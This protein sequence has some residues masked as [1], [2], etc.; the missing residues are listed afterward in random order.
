M[1]IG[2]DNEQLKSSI[3]RILSGSAGNEEFLR[4]LE[5]AIT[6]SSV[7]DPRSEQ[8]LSLLMEDIEHHGRVND[9]LDAVSKDS[10]SP[11][12]VVNED[13]SLL[14]CNPA[15]LALAGTSAPKDL[16]SLGV[17]RSDFVKFRERLAKLGGTSLLKVSFSDQSESERSVVF[18]GQY[19]S[20]SRYYLLE[21]L[22]LKW[23]ESI[24]QALHELFGL[25]PAEREVLLCMARGMPVG[26]ISNFRGSRISTVR[27]QVKT[28]LQ[29]TGCSTQSQAA[30][31][32]ATL[33][34]NRQPGEYP[35]TPQHDEADNRRTLLS[36]ASVS[37]GHSYRQGR[38]VGWR[39]YGREGGKV[40]LL[41]HS[42]Y[43]SAGNHAGE[44][45]AA[46]NAGYDVLV[47]ERPGFGLTY[48][49]DLPDT[50]LSTHL[51]DCNHVLAE[52]GLIPEVLISHDYGFVYALAYSQIA[53]G[54][55]PDIFAVS[56]IP[57][58]QEGSEFTEIPIQQRAFIWAAR[59]SF[60]LVRML[61][62]LGHVKARRLGPARWMEM[63]F[64]GAEEELDIFELDEGKEV[65]AD[66]YHFNLAQNSKG[67]ELDLRVCIASDWS[68]SLMTS[69]SSISILTG[70][71]NKTFSLPMVKELAELRPDITLSQVT[72]GLT[73]SV[74]YPELVYSH[75]ANRQSSRK[76]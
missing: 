45:S 26:D 66:S 53:D 8:S 63:V 29:K 35:V 48:E 1:T 23:S 30:A 17:V 70:S 51:K 64:E 46:S 38:R 5:P 41:M 50:T 42:A 22:E 13:G 37:S 10:G 62:R 76:A 25:T 44:I 31:L 2:F 74:R 47:I 72:T 21:S 7:L 9:L 43:F 67:H 34:E 12:L 14:C 57:R 33:G 16:Y 4:L 52:L 40:A 32:A 3:Q 60:W 58:F 6:A 39:R 61:L 73:L 19:F 24:E 11:K 69:P 59:H 68:A 18:T 75:L 36:Q 56:P 20:R 55:A 27:Q 15:A 28:I 54:N 65:A 71:E 49:P